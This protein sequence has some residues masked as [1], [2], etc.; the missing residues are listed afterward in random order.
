MLRLL[1]LVMPVALLVSIATFPQAV[2]FTI[3]TGGK[4]KASSTAHR[5]MTMYVPLSPASQTTPFSTHK[6][7][8]TTGTLGPKAEQRAEKRV[9]TS[10]SNSVLASCD[11]LPTFST[12][13][14]LLSPETVMRM[15]QMTPI[16]ER[17]E[18]LS[19]FLDT[20]RSRGPMS[21]LTFLSDP[22]ILPHL[23]LAMRDLC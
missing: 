15:D 13:H 7:L 6:I 18:A 20:Y 19:L 4:R 11:I 21:C 10:L 2:A 8:S 14:G 17:S 16:G 22:S 23:T 9:G 3:T 12:A 1:S 5:S